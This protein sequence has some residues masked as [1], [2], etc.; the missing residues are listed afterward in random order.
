MKKSSEKT[1]KKAPNRLTTKPSAASGEAGGLMPKRTK[2][3]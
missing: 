2:A 3:E 1:R